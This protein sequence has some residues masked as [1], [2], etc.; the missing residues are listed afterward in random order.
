MIE[1]ADVDVGGYSK[2]KAGYSFTYFRTA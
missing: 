2:A 1:S